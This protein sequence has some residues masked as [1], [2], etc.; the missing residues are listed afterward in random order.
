VSISPDSARQAA[1]LANWARLAHRTGELATEAARGL[2][3]AEA[4]A[5]ED[6]PVQWPAVL[7]ELARAMARAAAG[8]T[9]L[10]DAMREA[11]APA[12]EAEMAW[13]VRVAM[14]QAAA[15]A[16]D[17]RVCADGLADLGGMLIPS[18]PGPR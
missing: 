7:D 16:D 12:V 1:L 9:E 10:L 6:A 18:Q 11:P 17:L 8:C 14:D 5:G 4:G 13:A 2:R 3:A 15:A